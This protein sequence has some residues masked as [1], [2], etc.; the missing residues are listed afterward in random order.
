MKKAFLLVLVIVGFQNAVAQE[1]KGTQKVIYLSVGPNYYLNNFDEPLRELVDQA[2]Y[3]IGA[4]FMWEGEHRLALG[5]K[6]GFYWIYSVEG[7]GSNNAK[8]NLTGI[9]IEPCISMRFFDDFHV[10]YG[11]GPT[12]LFNNISSDQGELFSDSFLSTA[13]MSLS[14]G[15]AKKINEKHSFG[16]ELEYFRSSKAQDNLFSLSLLYRLPIGRK[17]GTRIK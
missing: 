16:V 9:P 5:I 11:I 14:A 8:I 12:L 13:D 2:H 10:T 6:S 1:K 15:Y 7:T 4:R 17:A 3:S